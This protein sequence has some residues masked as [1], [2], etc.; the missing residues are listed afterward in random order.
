MSNRKTWIPSGLLNQVHFYF[1]L[2]IVGFWKNI[3]V[4]VRGPCRMQTFIV[5]NKMIV[6]ATNRHVS[7]VCCM[8]ILHSSV[9]M[10]KLIALFGGQ[11]T[12]IRTQP[13]NLRHCSFEWIAY[14]VS[15]SMLFIEKNKLI[16]SQELGSFLDYISYYFYCF[17]RLVY[18]EAFAYTHTLHERR[19]K[20]DFL[21]SLVVG[22]Q[23]SDS[24]IER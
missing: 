4:Y 24:W 15:V 17:I 5:G 23:F 8:L 19:H 20:S 21:P 3:V 9:L 11:K 14:Y 2:T 13:F 1:I 12:W 18:A 22:E 10:R 6:R 7:K 16:L